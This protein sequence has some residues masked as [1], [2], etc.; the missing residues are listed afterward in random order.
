MPA[1]KKNEYEWAKHH[2]D[3]FVFVPQ[4]RESK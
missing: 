2:F 4:E 1:V 3:A